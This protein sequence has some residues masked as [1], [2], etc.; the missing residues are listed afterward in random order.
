MSRTL[1]IERE[2]EVLQHIQAL[3][4]LQETVASNTWSLERWSRA[5]AAAL[6]AL[7]DL[8]VEVQEGA[9]AA[10][11][12]DAAFWRRRSAEVAQLGRELAQA[13][14]VVTLILLFGDC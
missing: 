7:N 4:P 11:P 13:S 5:H 3:K 1:V 10:T 2:E 12:A 8:R 9:P 14:Q 6:R